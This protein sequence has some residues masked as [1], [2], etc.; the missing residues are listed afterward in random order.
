MKITEE[1][2]CRT[3]IEYKRRR[4]E[5]KNYDC[6]FHPNTLWLMNWGDRMRMRYGRPN[7]G[8]DW[9]RKLAYATGEEGTDHP[10][11]AAIEI[12]KKWEVQNPE[13]EF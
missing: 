13:E 5:M 10:S 4:F 9:C 2:H 6:E 1:Q 7:D 3:D 11:N 8:V 12:A